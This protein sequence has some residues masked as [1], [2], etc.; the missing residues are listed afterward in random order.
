MADANVVVRQKDNELEYPRGVVV[1]TRCRPASIDCIQDIGHR[2]QDD[3]GQWVDRESP[4][5]WNMQSLRDANYNLIQNACFC[6]CHYTD[7]KT[8]DVPVGN[9]R[10]QP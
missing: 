1:Y 5:C 2:Y 3:A 8:S 4:D 6:P 7:A 9:K 10:G